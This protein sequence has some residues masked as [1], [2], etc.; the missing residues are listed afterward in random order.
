VIISLGYYGAEERPARW[1]L[2]EHPHG[3]LCG[4][5]GSGKTY[6]VRLII[7]QASQTADVWLA[8]GK[9]SRDFDGL[10]VERVAK[11]PIDCVEL[12]EEAGSE[13]ASRTS[14]ASAAGP[15]VVVVDE[16]AAITLRIAGDTAKEARDRRDR[17]LA[18]LGQ[19]AL[20]GRSVRVHLLVA[21]QRPDADVL[22]GS[23]RDQFGLRVGLG[24]LSHDGY[25]MLLGSSAVVSS[26]QIGQG[27]ALGL[28][29]SSPAAK[30]LTV[31]TRNLPG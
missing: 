30:P 4:Q 7:E 1:D 8:D 27:W 13:L 20:M 15:L 18:A 26:Q 11:G 12:L 29:G 19:I 23:I 21:L 2:S 10:D 16:A 24:W 28:S 9:A 6:L 25:R 3:L 22:G 5:T 14:S 31:C 17:L